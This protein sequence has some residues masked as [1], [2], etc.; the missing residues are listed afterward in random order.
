MSE[1]NKRYLDEGLDIDERVADLVSRM[2][3]EVKV[4]QMLHEAPAV[5]SLGIPEYNWWNECLHGVARAGKTTVFS[6][7]IGMAASFDDELMHEVAVAI[8][9]DGTP[10]VEPGEFIISV[11]GGQPSDP[12]SR[13]I[14]T[15]MEL[16]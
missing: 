7:A 3:L 13:S 15:T 10:M 11:G 1:D 2:P 16:K 6:Q 8:S 5:P 9:D 4:S 14:S 12:N